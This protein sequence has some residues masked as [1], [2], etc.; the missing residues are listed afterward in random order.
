[1]QKG[2]LHPSHGAQNNASQDWQLVSG[3]Q[4]G[5]RHLMPCCQFSHFWSREAVPPFTKKKAKI[6]RLRG[7]TF[8]FC[9][10]VE[11]L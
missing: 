7:E 1:M 4:L 11:S 8:T 6:M 9:D 2:L 5:R 3:L 10:H